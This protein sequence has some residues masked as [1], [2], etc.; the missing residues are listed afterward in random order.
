MKPSPCELCPALPAGRWQNKDHRHNGGKGHGRLTAIWTQEHCL[1]ALKVHIAHSRGRL[2]FD[3][4]YMCLKKGRDLPTY[5]RLKNYFGGVRQAWLIAGAPEDRVPWHC[6]PWTKADEDLLRELAGTMK[7]TAIARKLRRSDA[8]VKRRLYDL[9]LKNREGLGYL[10]CSQAA[11]ELSCHPDLLARMV[12]EGRIPARNVRR[13]NNR[14]DIDLRDLTPEVRLE[15]KQRSARRT[16]YEAWTHREIETMIAMRQDGRT[17]FEIGRFLDRNYNACSRRYEMAYLRRPKWKAVWYVCL[18]FG[19]R[20]A[21]I[22]I[23][24]VL[25]SRGHVASYDIVRAAAQS[26]P[27]RLSWSNGVVS[28]LRWTSRRVRPEV[29]QLRAEKPWMVAAA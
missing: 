24:R 29:A 2:P 10:S 6:M 20:A 25:E 8:A 4:A 15:I 17:W 16:R 27:R 22:D 13:V 19:G 21:A 12:R 14:Y 5:E 1:E 9:G 3:N 11:R 7:R 26:Q 28:V 23:A 18:E